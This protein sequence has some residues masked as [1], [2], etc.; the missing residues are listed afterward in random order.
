MLAQKIAVLVL[1]ASDRGATPIAPLVDAVARALSMRPS[2]ELSVE[3]ESFNDGVLLSCGTDIR[4]VAKAFD[5]KSVE[6]ALLVVAANDANPPILA[7]KLVDL[8][9]VN[10]LADSRNRYQAGALTES[11][12]LYA[13]QLLDAEG[14]KK[15]ARLR[16]H[17]KPAGAAVALEGGVKAD[18]AGVLLADPGKYRVVATHPGYDEEAR[19]VEL[20]A[21]QET[22]VSIELDEDGSILESPW[23]WIA[24]GVVAAGVTTALVVGP[25]APDEACIPI[26]G[27]SC[28]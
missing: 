26:N 14:F 25:G 5:G 1:L 18:A 28:E 6:L 16:A 3:E 12:S 7:M 27:G 19:D 9:K 2:L 8:K 11:V 17:V 13:N 21:G 23:L 10:V 15:L 22:A 4:C 24:V 20:I